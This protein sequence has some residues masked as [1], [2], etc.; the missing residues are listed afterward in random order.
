[1]LYLGMLG[2]HLGAMTAQ[3]TML[4][5][6]LSMMILNVYRFHRTLA[7]ALVAV[8]ALHSL[9]FQIFRHLNNYYSG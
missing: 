1:M 8:L 5:Y 2:A 4:F 6:N 3:D 7:Q 9:K